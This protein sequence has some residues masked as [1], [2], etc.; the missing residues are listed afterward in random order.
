MKHPDH[1][2]FVRRPLVAYEKIIKDAKRIEERLAQSGASPALNSRIS[3]YRKIIESFL[4]IATG[5][6]RQTHMDW[7]LL[8]QAIF[9]VGQIETI[10][11]EFLKPPV[12]P[13][14]RS[15][16]LEL[17]SGRSLPQTEKEQSKARDIQ[18]ELFVAARCQASGYLVEP[19]EPDILVRDECGDFGIAA[20]RPKSPKTLERHI[21][22]GSHQ[23]DGSG[24][25]GIVAIDLSLIHNPENKILLFDKQGDD[26]E[27][28][29]RIADRFVQLNSHRIRSMV[30]LPIV[31]GVVV[32]MA[33]L[34]FVSKTLQFASATRWTIANL[35]EMSDPHYQQLR[36]FAVRFAAGIS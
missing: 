32:C 7:C 24:L 22:K 26:I 31:F 28:V 2:D 18:F 5:R 33:S 27:I 17:I 1:F 34:S 36:K 8:H 11:E 35:C 21:R 23:I 25:P 6:Q 10:V 13:E 3:Q 14:W 29:Q 15:R 16:V 19:K 30:K 20:K 9:E 12:S 4:D